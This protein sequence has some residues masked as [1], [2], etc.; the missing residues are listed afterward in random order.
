VVR[1]QEQHF[2]ETIV[3]RERE[4]HTEFRAKL[5]E[6]ERVFVVAAAQRD[7]AKRVRGLGV[8]WV[9]VLGF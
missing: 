5:E 7:E 3:R 1:A 6:Q 2:T 9:W 4:M 8:F